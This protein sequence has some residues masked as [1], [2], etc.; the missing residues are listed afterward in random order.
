M[1]L[2]ELDKFLK[3]CRKQGVTEIVYEELSVK[4]GD[5]PKKGSSSI[6]EIEESQ[7]EGGISDEQLMFAHIVEGR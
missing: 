6:E 3:L 7:L 4:F 5:M 2:K 1:E